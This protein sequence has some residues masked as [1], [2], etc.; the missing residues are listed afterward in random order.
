MRPARTRRI[1]IGPLMW[2]SRAKARSSSPTDTATTGSF[3]STKRGVSSGLGHARVA[4]GMFSLP[5]SIAVD[6]HGRLYVADR[7]NARIQVF[8]QSGRCLDE[9]RDLM[10][11]WHIVVTD[12]DEI[13]VCGSSPM[14][15]PRLPIPGLLV[16][17]PPKDQ[18]VMVFAPD[19]R[20]KRLWA[21]PRGSDRV[22]STGCTGWPSI[23]RETCI[24]AISRDAERSGFSGSRHRPPRRVRGRAAA[25]RTTKT[26]SGRASGEHEGT[27]YQ[28]HAL[29]VLLPTQ[30]EPS[31]GA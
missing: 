30:G 29:C 25:A 26:F 2:R 1:S 8:D 4:P 28:S 6:S 16:G 3:I 15:W 11:P 19:G 13:Y 31:C 22:N 7:N 21:F 24:W 9:W 27:T 12:Q 18:L 23:V 20:V 10:V 14:R 5:H 17:I